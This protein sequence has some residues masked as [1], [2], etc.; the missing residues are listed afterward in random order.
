MGKADSLPWCGPSAVVVETYERK[1]D[2]VTSRIAASALPYGQ[3]VASDPP[4]GARIE[5]PR[6]LSPLRNL[7]HVLRVRP[8]K[9]EGGIIR[10]HDY[11]ARKSPRLTM[12]ARPDFWPAIVLGVGP[13]VPDLKEGDRVYVY[14][15]AED[16]GSPLGLYTGVQLGP[17]DELLITYP[18]DV[19]CAV[20]GATW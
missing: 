14:T 3:F 12:A 1:A 4:P 9:S 13:R 17:K 10:L 19:V 16:T 8:E 15:F 11:K 2:E 6:K 7:V 20:E 18:D 5:L